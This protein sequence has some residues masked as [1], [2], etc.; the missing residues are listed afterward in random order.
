MR[1]IMTLLLRDNADILRANLDYH[2]AQG[3]DYVIATDNLSKDKTVD[4][5]DEYS[6]R[7]LLHV[8]HE[9]SDTYEQGRWVTRMARLAA[10][11]YE[12]D[13]IIHNDADEFWWPRC[14]GT[15]KEAFRGLSPEYNVV[16]AKRTNF[17]YRKPC[18]HLRGKPFFD[19]MIFRD[20]ISLNPIG[21]PLHAKV[22]HRSHANAVLPTGNYCV[23]NI[24]P[25]TICEDVFEIFHFPIRTADQFLEKIR[26][27]GAA[28]SNHPGLHAR[29]VGTWETLFEEFKESDK[30]QSYMTQHTYS[31]GRIIR[32]MFK[33]NLIRDTRLRDF[34]R[35]LR[36]VP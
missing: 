35:M 24:G 7:G 22:A 31:L 2:F 5:L 8:I 21:K 27:G 23:S 12:A 9:K 14:D 32:E 10:E 25:Q 1:L 15:L 30:F 28:V 6:E 16:T 20:R 29:K 18:R 19:S 13:W 36:A 17:V 26:C 11:E 33:G 34:M 4:I 3:V